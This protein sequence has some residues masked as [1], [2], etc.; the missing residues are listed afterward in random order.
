MLIKSAKT[1]VIT[2][3]LLLG[4][5]SAWAAPLTISNIGGGWSNPNP[6]NGEGMCVD[7]DN[8]PN[9]GV[10][11]IRWNS[12]SLV[13]DASQP[14]SDVCAAGAF[15]EPTSGYDFAPISSTY[16]FPTT[17]ALGQPFVLGT[18]THFNEAV[19]AAI[20]SV[21]Y[22]LTL[23]TNGSPS[24]LATT[25][26]F[27]HN[28]TSNDGVCAG[29]PLGPSQSVCDDFV[30]VAPVLNAL[31]QV[32]DTNYFFTLLG[33]SKDGLNFSNVFQ[34]PENMSNSA[35]LYGVVTT[36]AVPEPATLALL[37]TGLLGLGSAARRRSKKNREAAAAK[38]Q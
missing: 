34:S 14:G 17:N 11:S 33:F 5:A 1:L 15:N 32:G 25:L 8:A 4:T 7:I 37:G 27:S 9:A 30:T 13:A 22:D 10:D 6:A 24:T 29:G 28:E 20:S 26:Q 35:Q 23:S 12:N 38:Q 31:I 18:F 3:G 2:A 21:G 16:E 19:Y 36:S